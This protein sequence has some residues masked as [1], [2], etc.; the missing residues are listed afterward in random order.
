MSG[1]LIRLKKEVDTNSQYAA[2]V[3]NVPAVIFSTPLYNPWWH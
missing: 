2:I 1:T 3:G